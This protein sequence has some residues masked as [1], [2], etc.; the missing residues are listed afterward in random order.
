[1]TILGM[2]FN[3]ID[4]IFAIKLFNIDLFYW[5]IGVTILIFIFK[6]FNIKK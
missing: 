5:L 3:F 6:L 2:F 4:Q 1:M